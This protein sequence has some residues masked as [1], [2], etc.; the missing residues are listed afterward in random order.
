MRIE[1]GRWGVPEKKG[2]A[3]RNPSLGRGNREDEEPSWG[4]EGRGLLESVVVASLPL[5][6]PRVL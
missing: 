1:I 5:R 2:R 6:A 4:L 3:G